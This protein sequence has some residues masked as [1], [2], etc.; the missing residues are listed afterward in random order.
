MTSHSRQVRFAFAFAGS[1]NRALRQKRYLANDLTSFSETF[2]D[3][4]TLKT[5]VFTRVF[6]EFANGLSVVGCCSNYTIQI[7]ISQGIIM[8][9]GVHHLDRSHR[10][11]I[12]SA[13]RNTRGFEGTGEE[14][15]LI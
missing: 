13:V 3:L 14:L 2:G 12:S 9:L 8:S 1:M 15:F 5:Q 4:F 10:W 6:T 11:S 7:L